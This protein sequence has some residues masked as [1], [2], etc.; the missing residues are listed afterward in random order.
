MTRDFFQL[1]PFV[2]R[3]YRSCS[4]LLNIYKSSI[5]TGFAKQITPIL[6]ILCHKGSFV[7][8]TVVSLTAAKSKPLTCSVSGFALFCAANMF[9]LM[10]LYDNCL[11]LAQFSYIIVYILKVESRVQQLTGPAYNISVRTAQKTQFLCCSVIVGFVSVGVTTWS[12]LS[13]CLEM[14]VVCRAIT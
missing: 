8:W 14:A 3:T 7:T 4:R 10:I 13:H 1:N 2:K 9:I 12:L 5:S 11:L 6:R